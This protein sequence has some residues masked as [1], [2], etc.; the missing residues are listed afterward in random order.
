MSNTDRR[1]AWLAPLRA[2]G[3]VVVGIGVV[4]YTLL[5]ELLFPMV[6]PLIAWLGRLQLF[7]RLGALIG[8]SPPYAVLVLLAVPFVIIEPAKVYA[9]YLFATGHLVSGVVLLV[10]AQVLS[11][12]ICE[13]IYHA[14]HAPLMRIGWF[15]RLMGWLVALRDKALG[16]IRS[17]AAWRASVGMFRSVKAWFRGLLAAF[18]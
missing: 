11:L 13:R 5:D 16:L 8:C 18:R 9:L 15:R 4:V 17:T 10:I 6:R 1:P 12:L 3:R 7:A 14:G 2:I